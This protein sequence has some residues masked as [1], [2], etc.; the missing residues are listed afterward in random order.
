M[1]LESVLKPVL[2]RLEADQ[3][4][5][6][7][8]VLGNDDLLSGCLPQVAGEIVFNL[9]QG[10]FLHRGLP[11]PAARPRPGLSLRWQAL[12]PRLLQR[13][14]TPGLRRRAVDTAAAQDLAAA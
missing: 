2:L 3:H 7:P 11:L 12:P 10:Y 4:A 8:A 6:G 1:V 5:C 14:R 13:H 9:R